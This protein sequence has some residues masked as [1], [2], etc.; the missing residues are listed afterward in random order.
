MFGA[1]QA[2]SAGALLP[3]RGWGGPGEWGLRGTSSELCNRVYL[4]PL[5]PVWMCDL[6]ACSVLPGSQGFSEVELPG[7]R[8]GP[9]ARIMG[10]MSPGRSGDAVC[11]L[12]SSP[13]LQCPQWLCR[14]SGP[15]LEAWS[16]GKASVHTE[17]Y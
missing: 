11:C 9:R 1:V 14:A 7:E 5:A 6:A 15:G 2:A 8:Q 12:A 4:Y 17:F 3:S 13:R 16:V 10:S